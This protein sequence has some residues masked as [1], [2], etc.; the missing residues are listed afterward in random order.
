M[1]VPSSTRAAC[2]GMA[3]LLLGGLGGCA[4]GTLVARDAPA[5]QAA[6]S[7][8]R[9]ATVA[10]GIEVHARQRRLTAAERSQ[11]ITQLDAQAQAGDLLRHLAAQQPNGL[12]D[13]YA[14][15]EAD[16][17][18]DGPAT[19][20][21]MF[22]AIERARHTVLLESYIVEDAG[23][24]LRLA[25]LLKRKRAQGVQVAMIYDDVGSFGTAASYFQA[26]RDNGVPTCA[27]NP[28][29]PKRRMAYWSLAHR[30]HRKILVVDG[31][32]AFTGGINISAVYR[33]GSFSRPK[34]KAAAAPASSTDQA[35]P[36]ESSEHLRQNGWR[37][38]QVR[39]TGAAAQALDT[40]VRDTWQHQG[41]LPAL[42][43]PPAPNTT[44]KVTVTT[45]A[46][47]P[48]VAVL[49]SS[50][51]DPF[52]RIYA[53]LLTAIDVSRR[54]VWFTMAYFA[55]TADMIDALSDAARRGVDVRL[56]LPSQS[57]FSPVLHAGRSH[58]TTLLDAG[59]QLCELQGA[60][61]HAK[62]VV[63]DGVLSSVGS[64]NLDWRSFAGNN[65]V[66]A[67]VFGE[68]FALRMQAM[69]ESDL[70][71]CAPVTLTAWRQRP[72]WQ[73]AKEAAAG[74]LERLW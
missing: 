34:G 57:D 40:L 37:D 1:R 54:S 51:L 53:T 14:G 72:V 52:N 41:C 67:L 70:R 9:A 8:P 18:I 74:L 26:L 46:H 69:F 68:D 3:A 13:L 7:S 58:Y 30:D 23:I 45:A 20:K 71:A 4:A 60:V 28:L 21:A 43:D 65:E 47:S 12:Q 62:T 6:T 59:V 66:N 33:S 16:L 29:V 11:L 64:S 36:S 17:L 61:L 22:A 27:F 2:F 35:A 5:E 56:I 25:T 31:E 39:L 73:R 24:A 50:P 44:T 38:T 49:P 15:G 32:V 63:I 10:Q 19:F 48:L 42:P 55:P